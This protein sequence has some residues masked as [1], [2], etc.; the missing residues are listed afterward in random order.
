RTVL[1]VGRLVE[2][3]GFGYLVEAAARLRVERVWI[4]GDGPLRDELERQIARLG[5]EDTVELLGAR[6]HEEV[7]E[8][9]EQAAVVAM[10][11]VVAADGDRDTMPVVVK[12]AL[13]MEVP[14]VAS[15]EVG[16]PEVV[17]QGWGRLA[18]PG[19][20]EALAGALGELLDLSPEARAEMGR[21]G[22]AFV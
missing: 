22:R 10:P 1:A 17:H 19:D 7:R 21:A 12:E 3:K 4:V 14:V 8:L 5:L 16:L 15:D 11:S 6:G 20:P 13:A 2:K 18:P 9:L